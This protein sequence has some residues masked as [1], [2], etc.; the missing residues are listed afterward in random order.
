VISDAHTGLKAARKAVLGG[1]PWQRCQFRLQQNAQ[2]YVPHK[3]RQAEVAEDIRTI[4]NAP[5]LATATIYLQKAVQKY[6][7]D[8]SRLATW[9]EEN[10]PEGLT[11]FQFPL[12]HR[13]K[14]RTNNITERLNREIRRRTRVVSIFPN[15]VSC[16][17]LVSAILNETS[18]KMA[19]R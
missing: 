19:H 13:K 2:T 10:I 3:D 6:Q 1:V 7:K 14:I 8:A 4:F 17:R 11:V 18:E 5:D 15:S 9:M 12:E 16:L